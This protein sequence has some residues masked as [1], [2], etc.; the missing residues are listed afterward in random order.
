MHHPW[1]SEFGLGKCKRITTK[2]GWTSDVFAPPYYDDEDYA[3]DTDELS[4]TLQ[5]GS[6]HAD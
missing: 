3:S 1:A 4:L 2:Y 6:L 5:Q